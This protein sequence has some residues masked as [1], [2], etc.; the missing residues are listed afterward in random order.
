[1]NSENQPPIISKR[2]SIYTQPK[3][4]KNLKGV[5]GWLLLLCIFLTAIKPTFILLEL[6]TNPSLFGWFWG[7]TWIIFSVAAGAFLWSG[8][9]FGLKIAQI[10]L[11]LVI[12]T[13]LGCL[14]WT[15]SYT[16]S[17]SYEEVKEHYDAYKENTGENISW[18]EYTKK[19]VHFIQFYGKSPDDISDMRMRAVAGIAAN[20]IFLL[21]LYYSRRVRNT[22]L[23][24]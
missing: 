17:H 20:F 12:G 16:N 24:E 15:Y 5:D 3:L 8:K 19:F 22:Y 13:N 14:F 10:F 18:D 6:L 7:C 4:P 1:M 23:R 2:R 21:Y 9:S 11:W